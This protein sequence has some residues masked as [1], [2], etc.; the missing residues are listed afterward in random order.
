MTIFC[1]LDG[2]LL[3][4][5]PRY[6]A[7]LKDY[8]SFDRIPSFEEY[9]KSRRSGLSEVGL[10]KLFRPDSKEIDKY[11]VFRNEMIESQKY[12]AFDK[13]FSN[14]VIG[15][16]KKK[17]KLVLLTYRKQNQNLKM[18]VEDF[19]IAGLFDEIITPSELFTDAIE[20]KAHFISQQ[21]GAKIMIGDSKA[22]IVA[23]QKNNIVSVGV[24]TGLSDIER[25]KLLSPSMII[26]S[27]EDFHAVPELR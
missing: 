11:I 17:G 24:L 4:F 23:A 12:L 14:S 25:M 18:Q 13:L 21:E 3:D 20:F 10:V 6:Y 16:L 15:D 9:K 1:D 8:F 2:T 27:I 26:E 22:D 19:Q 5:F 7:I